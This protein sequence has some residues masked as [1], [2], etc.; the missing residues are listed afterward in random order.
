MRLPGP[1]HLWAGSC[2]VTTANRLETSLK[3]VEINFDEPRTYAV[4]GSD[5]DATWRRMVRG[6]TLA[7]SA[8]A[9]RDTSLLGMT[10]P[11]GGFVSCPSEN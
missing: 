6:W 3:L 9:D 5:P 1:R 10:K 7:Y 11:F 4:G 8:A 2:G